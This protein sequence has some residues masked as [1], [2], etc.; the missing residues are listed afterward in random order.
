LVFYALQRRRILWLLVFYF[1][2]LF[3]MYSLSFLYLTPLNGSLKNGWWPEH[4][5]LI[6]ILGLHIFWAIIFI[7]LSLL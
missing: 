7:S 5:K 1:H 6:P 3:L 2:I 4:K